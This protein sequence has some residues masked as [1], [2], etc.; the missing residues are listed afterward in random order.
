M[1]E[2]VRSMIIASRSRASEQ[3]RIL[4]ISSAAIAACATSAP[5]SS[6]HLS[7]SRVSQVGEICQTVMGFE[8]SEPLVDNLWPGDPDPESSTNKYR[9]CVASLSNSLVSAAAAGEESR[10][11]EVCRASGLQ[12]GNSDF[13]VCVAQLV[14][15]SASTIDPETAPLTVIPF[16]K[17]TTT[18][19]FSSAPEMLRRE[20]LA[21]AEV[22]LEPKQN[23]FASCV[24]GLSDV[25]AAEHMNAGYRNL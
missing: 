22:G 1:S 10:A 9:G 3:L 24:R 23:A 20:R 19:S 2:Q 13:G 15:A 16:S 8:P 11:D 25:L 17:E 21:C 12:P 7:A 18:G 4:C 14:E 5:Y 6:Q